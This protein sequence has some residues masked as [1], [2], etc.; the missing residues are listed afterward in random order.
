MDPRAG[1]CTLE[2][3]KAVASKEIRTLDL[4]VRSLVAATSTPRIHCWTVHVL[5]TIT[6]QSDAQN[7]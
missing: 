3:R 4:P 2:K 5:A 6:T 7:V 1:L